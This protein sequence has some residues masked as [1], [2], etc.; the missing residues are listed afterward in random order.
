MFKSSENKEEFLDIGG[1]THCG[2]MKFNGKD[3]LFDPTRDLY[4]DE[5]CEKYSGMNMYD[6]SL[7]QEFLDMV[8]DTSHCCDYDIR[9]RMEKNE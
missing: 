9:H 4:D 3:I 1:I 2:D 8:F 6:L 5:L 7:H